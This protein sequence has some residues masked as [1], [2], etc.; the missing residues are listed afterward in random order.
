MGSRP[1]G[2]DLRSAEAERGITGW[3][4]A[5]L[6][7]RRV[8]LLTVPLTDALRQVIEAQRT[9]VIQGPPQAS[10]AVRADR[11]TY[12]G[13]DYKGLMFYDACQP[14]PSEALLKRESPEA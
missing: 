7:H 8:E 5:A 12:T 9:Q 2:P 11:F 6:T 3:L 10:T 4:K 1:S 14:I 13:D